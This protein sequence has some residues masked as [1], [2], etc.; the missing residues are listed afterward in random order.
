MCAVLACISLKNIYIYIIIIADSN[1]DRGS[2]ENEP[3]MTKRKKQRE[4]K[5]VYTKGKMMNEICDE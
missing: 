3:K 2:N 5:A 1:I 4:N